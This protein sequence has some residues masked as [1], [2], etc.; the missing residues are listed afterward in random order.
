MEDAVKD[1]IV[2]QETADYVLL[3]LIEVTVVSI[4]EGRP[5]FSSPLK[6]PVLY[7][8]YF[9]RWVEEGLAELLKSQ[10]RPE[11]L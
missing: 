8:R 7:Q 1:A 2:T 11:D 4:Q 9:R 10:M 5:L 6:E 3:R